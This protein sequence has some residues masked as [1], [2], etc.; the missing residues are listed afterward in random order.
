MSKLNV[1]HPSCSHKGFNHNHCQ[2]FTNNLASGEVGRH[3]QKKY[4]HSNKFNLFKT[5]MPENLLDWYWGGSET[6]WLSHLQL[7]WWQLGFPETKCIPSWA[8]HRQVASKV[9]RCSRKNENS[10]LDAHDGNT[11]GSREVA[12]KRVQQGWTDQVKCWKETGE[13]HGR[14]YKGGDN[15]RGLNTERLDSRAGVWGCLN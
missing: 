1:F 2:Q 6:P 4:R 3:P 15:L 5:Y 9:R 14:K 12:R 11:F 8:A 13:R 10:G 7:A